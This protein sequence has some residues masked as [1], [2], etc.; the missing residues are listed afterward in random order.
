[1]KYACI[2]RLRVEHAVR[3]L[4]AVLEVGPSGYYAWRS[5]SP[6][7][8]ALRD[9]V[10]LARIE[11]VHRRSRRRYGAPRIHRALAGEGVRV[12]RKRVARL[13]RTARLRAVGR[14]RFRVTTQS[15]H[16]APRA[17]NRLARRF[18]VSAPGGRD[19]VWA[20]DLTYIPTGEGW[21]YLAVILDLASRR[22]VGWAVRERL[23]SELALAALRQALAHRRPHGGLHHSDQ[24]VQYASTAYRALLAAAGIEASMSR[25]GDCWDNAV[26]ESFFAT[27]TKELLDVAPFPTRAVARHEL[28]VF[29]DAWYNRE[30]LHSSLGYRSPITY[31][32]EVLGSY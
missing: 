17:P 16:A 13:M 31:E 8:R 15:A 26:V 4:C 9:A 27:L 1:V 12:A 20:A 28:T 10:L 21:L 7:G 23:D 19:R 5:R 29:I 2:E 11:A 18:G 3:R 24:G 14:R 32:L 30:R 25:T 22:V 6:S